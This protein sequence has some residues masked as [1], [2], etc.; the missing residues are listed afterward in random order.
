MSIPANFT[1]T[2]EGYTGQGAFRFWCQTVLPLVYDDSLSYYEL[3]NKVIAYLNNTVSD[4]SNAEKNINEL[5]NSFIELQ[6]YV[7]DFFYSGR[8]IQPIIDAWLEA[9][10]EAT[11]TVLDHSLTRDKFTQTDISNYLR[12]VILSSTENISEQFTLEPPTLSSYDEGFAYNSAL[13]KLLIAYYEYGDTTQ[14]SIYVVNP[15]THVVDNVYSYP[16]Y[17]ITSLNYDHVNNKIFANSASGCY[18]ID[19]YDMSSYEPFNV[20]DLN[21]WSYDDIENCYFAITFNGTTH[22]YTIKKYSTDFELIETKIFELQT[23]DH[24]QQGYTSHNNKIYQITWHS[25]MEIDFKYSLIN[26]LMTTG[27]ME[28]EDCC[29]IGDDLYFIAHS[30]AGNVLTRIYKNNVNT[31]PYLTNTLPQSRTKWWANK[32][33]DLLTSDGIYDVQIPSSNDYATYSYPY[34]EGGGILVVY[35][36]LYDE[37]P[38][39]I[40]Y[41]FQYFLSTTTAI[42][43]RVFTRVIGGTSSWT[44]WQQLTP[45]KKRM[46][47]TT[48][49]THGFA[50]LEI[51]TRFVVIGCYI[52]TANVTYELSQANNSWRIQLKS[53]ITHEYSKGVS[54][55]VTIFY[56]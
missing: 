37:T 16:F 18:L 2:L 12:G 25:I 32:S 20:D 56:I 27:S 17:P 31:T 13:N 29:F 6:A 50:D 15:T 19:G 26:R 42:Y 4:V 35:T 1:P 33:L 45:R 38:N 46:T 14:T 8:E 47:I 36:R 9:H 51:D 41:V 48:D 43:Y 54:T 5:L 11:T 52:S 23:T 34:M 53:C 44:G 3:L 7:N 30:I 24:P 49:S 39:T 21:D 55:S 22:E 28:I 10:P 40:H